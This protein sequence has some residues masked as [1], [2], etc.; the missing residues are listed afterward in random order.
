MNLQAR[1]A[2]LEQRIEAA[3]RGTGRRRDEVTL[4]A[5][6]KTH[7]SEQVRLAHALG[8]RH[9]GEN[10][11]QELSQKAATLA[12]V[13]P[14][15]WH[16]IGHLQRNKARHVVGRCALI[17]SVDSL[18]LLTRI[19]QLAAP[20]GIV[21]DVMLQLSLAGETS[22]SGATPEELEAL[23]AHARPLA[24]VRCVGL[25]TMPPLSASPD[26]ATSIFA[27]LR[28]LRD[29]ARANAP[30]LSFLSMGMSHDLELAIAQ[31]ATHIR[32]GSALFGDRR[33]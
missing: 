33:S 26:Q 19:D 2:A 27:E 5:V 10:Y 18:A 31:G 29:A 17:H 25:M 20:L 30:D 11:T 24:H 1:L 13:R 32:V 15:S 22:K 12:D 28:A 3:C 9:F 8:L 7:P 4:V 16:F 6:T 14:I 23:L 21:Q